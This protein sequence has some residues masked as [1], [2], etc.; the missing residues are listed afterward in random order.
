MVEISVSQNVGVSDAIQ[1]IFQIF[2]PLRNILKL[3]S[4]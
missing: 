4:I 2:L 1:S 3:N